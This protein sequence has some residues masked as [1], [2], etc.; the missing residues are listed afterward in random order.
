M[1]PEQKAKLVRIRALVGVHRAAGIAKKPRKRIPI[2]LEPKAIKREYALRLLAIVERVRISLEPMLAELPALLASAARERGDGYRETDTPIDVS[3]K[4]LDAGEGK[5]LRELLEAAGRRLASTIDEKDIEELAREFAKKTDTFQRIQ[6][7]RQVRAALGADVLATDTKLASLVDGFVEENVALIKDLPRKMYS[8]I[9][10]V[11]MR[12]VSDAKLH[13]NIAEEIEEKFELGRD[14]AKLIARDQVGKF[15]GQ[16]A[17]SRQ[18]DLG[19][20]AYIWRTSRDRRVRGTPGG[21][22]PHAKPSHYAREGKR[23]LLS[24][25]PEGG[26]PGQPVLCRCY[27]EPDFSPLLR[28]D[29]E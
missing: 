2:T 27:P 10:G 29:E 20:D 23:F 16:V 7:N 19:L 1:T 3:I 11:V 28:D 22:F 18:K 12:G 24:E 25:P 8:D 6:M 9:E 17:I 14:R 26:H 13:G 15:Y 21:A 4:R 5:R